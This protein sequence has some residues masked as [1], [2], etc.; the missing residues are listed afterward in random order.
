MSIL[1]SFGK[2]VSAIR[3]ERGFSQEDLADAADLHRT[4]ISSLERGRRN[5]TLVTIKSLAHALG[6]SMGDL[7]S[8]I[9][10]E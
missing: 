5:P 10:D 3:K 8:G 1:D 6:V 2:R 7:V 4:Y 9:S